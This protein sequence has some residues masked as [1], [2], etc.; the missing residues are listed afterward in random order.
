MIRSVLLIAAMTSALT[1]SGSLSASELEDLQA[2]C[3]EQERQIRLLEEEVM[4]LRSLVG[5]TRTVE[6]PPTPA[7]APPAGAKTPEPSAASSGSEKTYIVKQGDSLARIARRHGTTPATLARLNGLANPGMIKPGQSLKL[8]ASTGGSQAAT[9]PA[10][11]TGAAAQRAASE[12]K[13]HTVRQGDTFF[14]I[15]RKYGLSTEALIAANPDIKPSAMRPGQVVRLETASSAAASTTTSPTTPRSS[16][17]P[18]PEIKPPA[19]SPT[20]PATTGAARRPDSAPDRAPEVRPESNIRT[21][22][23]DGQM[24]YRQFA[25]KYGTTIERLNKLNGLSLEAHTVLAKGSE[26]HV[27]GQP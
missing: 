6:N 26:L 2:I 8:P 25:E 13:T 19:A 10:P 20:E 27:P 4:R 11:T 14:S 1:F 5:Q 12:G 7:V 9:P 15:A 18:K 16:P 23:T 22:T 24:T 3:L 21:V 17:T